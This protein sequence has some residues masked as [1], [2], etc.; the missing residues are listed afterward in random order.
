MLRARDRGTPPAQLSGGYRFSRRSEFA[1]VEKLDKSLLTASRLDV[2]ANFT[3]D[4]QPPTG[5]HFVWVASRA[6]RTRFAIV[7]R[8]AADE[9]FSLALQLP[10]DVVLEDRM[11]T[12]DVG[13]RVCLMAS[14]DLA[15]GLGSITQT[16]FPRN[17]A[18]PVCRKPM[19]VKLW[20]GVQCQITLH[21]FGVWAAGAT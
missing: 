16:G 8:R 3:V 1:A 14:V 18:F 6:P 10:G 15:R 19:V 13:S 5:L 11:M 9:V 4:A 21:E 7:L 2:F 12:Y 20:L 17:A